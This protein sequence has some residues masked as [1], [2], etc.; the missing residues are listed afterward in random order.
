MTITAVI[1]DL[2]GVLIDTESVAKKAWF[3][4]AVDC[5]FE[6]SEQLYTTM[7]GRPVESCRELIVPLLPEDV[8]IDQFMQRSAFLYFDEMERNGIQ[9]V[10]GILA[11]LDWVE[12]AN[13][14]TAIAT[15]SDRQHA[16]RKLRMAGLENRIST[17]I[18]CNDVKRGK[19]APDLFLL[20][21]KRLGH[22]IEKC[23]VIDDSEAGVKGAYQSGAVP[24][25]LP[26]TVKA[27]DEARRVCYAIN[28][29]LDET[30]EVIQTLVG[31]TDPSII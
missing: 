3:E 31:R 20:A 22:A 30:L 1:L 28:D 23:L 21:A 13:L 16:Q 5:G 15:S 7:V 26:S 19:P 8:E 17:M 2:D 25:M 10:P 14:A 24:I 6:F 4:A 11:L 18:T 12:E 9:L 29:T 27:S